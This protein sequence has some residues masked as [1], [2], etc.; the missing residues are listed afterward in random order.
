MDIQLGNFEF[1]RVRV[2]I[3]RI[4][5]EGFKDPQTGILI[6]RDNY[7][8]AIEYANEMDTNKIYKRQRREL[9]MEQKAAG[10]RKNRM[11]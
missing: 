1:R 2:M 3:F 7:E 11:R 9:R 4:P 8:T 10:S 6:K 5:E